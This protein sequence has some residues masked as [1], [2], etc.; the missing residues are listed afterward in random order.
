MTRLAA[1][2]GITFILMGGPRVGWRRRRIGFVITVIDEQTNRGVPLVELTAVN[3][4]RYV[5]DSRLAWW[6][7]M[8]RVHESA[9]FLQHCQ[10]W[11]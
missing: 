1:I 5:T 2:A 6:P 9:R 7:S 11:V 3:H 8:S 10:S 4:I